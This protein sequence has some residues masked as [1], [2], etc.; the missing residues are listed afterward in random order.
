MLVFVEKNMHV[1]KEFTAVCK[2]A[3][4]TV[5]QPHVNNNVLQYTDMSMFNTD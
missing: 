4:I 2:M 1:L 3:F 5:Y